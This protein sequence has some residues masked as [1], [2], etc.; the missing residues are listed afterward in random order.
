MLHREAIVRTPKPLPQRSK[1]Y[2]PASETR[3]MRES[4]WRF[5]VPLLFLTLAVSGCAGAP[6]VNSG[7]RSS[8]LNEWDYILPHQH[9][10]YALRY[11]ISGP[12][13]Q[14][15]RGHQVWYQANNHYGIDQ[16]VYQEGGDLGGS[17]GEPAVHAQVGPLLDTRDDTGTGT[18]NVNQTLT[19]R[20]DPARGAYVSYFGN[21][22]AAD[23]A[24]AANF[25]LPNSLELHVRCPAGTTI[26]LLG[27]GTESMPVLLGTLKGAATASQRERFGSDV[28]VQGSASKTFTS[29]MVSFRLES[30]SGLNGAGLVMMNHPARQE[31]WPMYSLLSKEF[32]DGPG[33]YSITINDARPEGHFFAIAIGF[34]PPER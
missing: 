19:F 10:A 11:E 14:E 3:F 30:V 13:D 15:C 32:T 28:V 16:L 34:N 23:P 26:K 12:K 5:G 24:F 2:L 29:A 27:V 8:P 9:G 4:S 21:L 1:L 7:A 6:H 22:T 33:D 25:N 20:L 18:I 17:Y 31:A